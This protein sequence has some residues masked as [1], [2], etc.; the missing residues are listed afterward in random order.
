M[1]LKNK[2]KKFIKI[3]YFS[4]MYFYKNRY[5]LI[6][7]L[8]LILLIYVYKR[9]KSVD[10]DNH[11]ISTANYFRP[12][13]M[14]DSKGTHPFISGANLVLFADFVYDNKDKSAKKVNRIKDGHVVFVKTD[15]INIFFK[16]IFP[17]INKKFILITHNSDYPTRKEHVKYLN[18]RKLIAWFAQ[19]PG[20]IHEKQIALPIGFG[21]PIWFGPNGN[22][23]L[24]NKLNLI[25]WEKREYLIYIN[26]NAN[27]NENARKN[28][29]K[30]FK[31]F[32]NVFIPDNRVS[33]SV[34]MNHIGNSKYVL[35]PSGNGLDTHRVYE[36][37]LMNSIPIVIN[38]T[39]NLLYK[40]STILIVDKFE[41]ITENMLSNPNLFIKN[42]NFTKHL[43]MMDYWTDRINSFK[44]II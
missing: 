29:I 14:F 11:S 8:N 10:D 6:V 36:T 2:Y 3:F 18:N 30:L 12:D 35:C 40:D 15:F 28:L 19:N 37:I 5:F 27:T 26:F 9:F 24:K 38:S 4:Q 17:N 25:A 42:M 31:Q 20:F 7:S 43:L 39:L 41:M 1:T 34:Y 33:Y 21:N 22:A 32:N 13:L 23:F 44:K 16:R